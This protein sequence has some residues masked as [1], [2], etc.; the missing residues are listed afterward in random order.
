MNLATTDKKAQRSLKAI[1]IFNWGDCS[2]PFCEKYSV[3]LHQGMAEEILH[4][5]TTDCINYEGDE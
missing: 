2:G 3:L 5:L 4:T 1:F